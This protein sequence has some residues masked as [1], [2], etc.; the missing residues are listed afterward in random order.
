[1]GTLIKENMEA[2][3]NPVTRVSLC[4]VRLQCTGPGGTA[5][6]TGLLFAYLFEDPSSPGQQIQVPVIVTN[7]HVVAGATELQVQFSIFPDGKTIVAD[8]TADGER[9][10]DLRVDNLHA[11][12]L[13]HPD[14]G[15]DLCVIPCAPW[16]AQIPSGWQLRHQFISDHWRLSAAER[17]YTRPIENVIMLGYPNGLWDDAHNRPVSRS[18]LTG[19]H[20]LLA[21]RGKREFVV[22]IACFPGSSGSPIFLLEDGMYRSSANA[23][24]PG[25][26]VKFLG[27]L[28]GG[29]M[30]NL[31]GRIE[32]RVVP[33][34]TG[35]VP[36]MSATMNLGYAIQADVLDDLKPVIARALVPQR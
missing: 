4:T 10:W 36:V 32:S 22:D 27:I 6:G 8:G 29:P 26:R 1:M 20:P 28:W 15:T 3:L 16:F 9:S 14:A 13:S 24:S 23:Y 21:W 7:K 25:T 11:G 2:D 18:G 34:G 31:E 33:T 12:V 19:S 30:I 17:L 5:I 35:D